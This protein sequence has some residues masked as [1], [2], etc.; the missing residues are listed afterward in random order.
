MT[1]FFEGFN[2][3]D[4][5]HTNNC[6]PLAFVLFHPVIDDGPGGFGYELVKENWEEFSP[7]HPMTAN[8]PPTRVMHDIG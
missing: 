4:D 7:L 1:A 6:K 5:D 8:P 2:A 3:P